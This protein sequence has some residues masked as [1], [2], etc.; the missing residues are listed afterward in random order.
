[1]R[2]R[3]GREELPHVVGQFCFL[4]REL[5]CLPPG[6]ERAGGNHRAERPALIGL[7]VEMPDSFVAETVGVR[8]AREHVGRN[9]LGQIPLTPGF[10]GAGQ[11]QVHC[12]QITGMVPI[13]GSDEQRHE[14]ARLH[15]DILDGLRFHLL[16]PLSD[17]LGQALTI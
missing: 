7:R 6:Q 15:S 16:R 14:V 8:I 4:I 17:A 1:M 11:H 3:T 10:A 9:I 12:G 13:A 5:A 2:G